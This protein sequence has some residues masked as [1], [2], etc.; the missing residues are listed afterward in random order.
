MLQSRAQN[1]GPYPGPPESSGAT[2]TVVPVPLKN[3]G[4]RGSARGSENISRLVVNYNYTSNNSLCADLELKL[5]TAVSY[6]EQLL[7]THRR[8]V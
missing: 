5:E 8:D 2:R 3:P 7:Y 6:C 4:A 1:P